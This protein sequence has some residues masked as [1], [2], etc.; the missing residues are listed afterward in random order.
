VNNN[1]EVLF[2]DDRIENIKV[3]E[4]YGITGFYISSEAKIVD[5]NNLIN[6]LVVTR[7]TKGS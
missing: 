3:A 2:V 1:D 7:F 4:Q 5:L 6:E